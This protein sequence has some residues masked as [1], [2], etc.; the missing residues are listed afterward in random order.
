MTR[1]EAI[2]RIGD[3]HAKWYLNTATR[4][5]R[6]ELRRG[7]WFCND[8]ATEAAYATLDR[9][10]EVPAEELEEDLPVFLRQN[11]CVDVDCGSVHRPGNGR[12]I[13]R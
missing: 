4:S 12:D 7:A 6:E 3:D 9:R 8:M 2:K 13:R 11:V 10:E 5:Q 1:T